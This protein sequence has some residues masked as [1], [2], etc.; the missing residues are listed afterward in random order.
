MP[1]NLKMLPFCAWELN[2]IIIISVVIHER[3]KTTVY[4][5]NKIKSVFL[6]ALCYGSREC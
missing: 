1:R 4:D 6:S 3:K 2:H 5:N